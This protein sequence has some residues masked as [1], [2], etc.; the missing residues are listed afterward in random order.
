MGYNGET[1]IFI[2]KTAVVRAAQRLGGS[3]GRRLPPRC[4]S[5]AFLDQATVAA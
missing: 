4:L 2:P 3:R 5:G 1:S